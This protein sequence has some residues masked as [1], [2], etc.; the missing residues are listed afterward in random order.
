M[1]RLT[2]CKWLE[3][4]SFPVWP[5]QGSCQQIRM[6]LFQSPLP[7]IPP[8]ATPASAQKLFKSKLLTTTTW[9]KPVVDAGSSST[10][11]YQRHLTHVVTHSLLKYSFLGLRTAE[12]NG[13]RATF[14]GAF[15]QFPLWDHLSLPKLYV[16][17]H[18]LP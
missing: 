4:D 13:F 10:F 15:S 1:L 11:A 2:F 5:P 17:G 6:N 12:P 18:V 8:A 9:P 16:L 3:D 7:S 14:I